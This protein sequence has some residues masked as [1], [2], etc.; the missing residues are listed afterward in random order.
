MLTKVL[1]EGKRLRLAMAS[2]EGI[3][4]RWCLKEA[5]VQSYEP[6]LPRTRSGEQKRHTRPSFR[7]SLHNMSEAREFRKYGKGCGCVGII[8]PVI[9]HLTRNP[10]LVTPSLEGTA[11]LTGLSSQV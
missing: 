6:S 2:Q 4:A 5:G 1:A 3:I 10:Q 7:V 9:S 8:C 11:V